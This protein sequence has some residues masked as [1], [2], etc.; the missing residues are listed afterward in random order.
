MMRGLCNDISA[1]AL[2]A[3]GAGC[4]PDLK[5]PHVIWVGVRDEKNELAHL[6]AA[7]CSM[8]KPF[9]SSEPEERFTAHVTL[10]RIK[11]IARP[12]AKILIE[13]LEREAQPVF[14][15]WTADAIELMRS[16]L[17]DQGARHTSLARIPFGSVAF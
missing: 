4:F 7:I 2:R 12:E 15:V 11:H 8:T 10:G 5:R 9:V 6:Q 16:E 1:F 13:I 3:Q 14:G 17:S